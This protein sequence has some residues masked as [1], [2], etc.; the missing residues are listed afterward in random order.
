[1]SEIQKVNSP[2]NGK[3]S[4][5]AREVHC[6]RASRTKTNAVKK[7]DAR[8]PAHSHNQLPTLLLLCDTLMRNGRFDMFPKSIR[9]RRFLNR[10]QIACGF[11]YGIQISQKSAAKLA[12]LKMWMI[13]NPIWAT[14]QFR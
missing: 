11:G 7:L 8:N 10:E 6:R 9:V 3:K 13:A 14:K 2:G 12:A 1:M 4:N 5:A